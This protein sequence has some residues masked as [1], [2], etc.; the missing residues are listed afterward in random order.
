MIAWNR[1]PT[2]LGDEDGNVVRQLAMPR[3]GCRSGGRP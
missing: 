3:L 1:A 2:D